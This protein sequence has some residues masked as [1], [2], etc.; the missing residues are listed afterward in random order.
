MSQ[1]ISSSP[2]QILTSSSN[3]DLDWDTLDEPISKT[4]IRD[5]QNIQSKLKYV[6][7][8]FAYDS[9]SI[10]SNICKNWDLWGPFIFSAFLSFSIKKCDQEQSD[11][12]NDP[13]N[14]HQSDFS[15]FFVLLWIGLGV[16]SI[17]FVLLSK[18]RPQTAYE[19]FDHFTAD[20][21]TR[22]NRKFYPMS[23]FQS[24]SIFG[25][26]LAIPCIGVL[27][28]KSTLLIINRQDSGYFLFEKFI[29]IFFCCFLYPFVSLN[30]IFSAN[31]HS[32][33][34]FLTVFPIGLLL[35]V[36]TFYIYTFI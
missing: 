31:I 25:Y 14:Q 23:F 5:L 21:L 17:N 26:F 11:C 1:N 35:I 36:L 32:D 30:Q 7:L 28:Q 8:P 19:E 9:V 33:K 22:S 24:L 16:L 6:M 4:I 2:I 20:N 10:Y 27:L 12:S 13:S 18:S 15:T 34:Y 29:I 3:L